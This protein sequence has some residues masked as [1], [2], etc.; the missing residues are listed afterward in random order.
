MQE[1]IK[2]FRPFLNLRMISEMPSSITGYV[3]N[4]YHFHGPLIH[5]TG[6]DGAPAGHI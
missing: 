2:V 4:L 3:M 6:L 1:T 5:A